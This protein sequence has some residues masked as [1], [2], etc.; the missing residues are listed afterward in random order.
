MSAKVLLVDDDPYNLVTLESILRPEGYTLFLAEDGEQ[1][2]QKAREIEPDVVVL[3]VMMPR[4]N[5]F[6]ACR[7]IRSDPVIGR[8]PILLL[9]ALDDPDSRLE[10]LRGGADDF[11]TKPCNRDEL[12]ARVRTV[13]ALNRF[14]VIAE[15]RERFKRLF[16][17]APDPILLVD[18][19]GGIVS[20]NRRATEVFGL[21]LGGADPRRE[22]ADLFV[23]DDAATVRDLVAESGVRVDP[24]PYTLRT[25][26]RA[27]G[28]GGGGAGERTF[29][30][31]ATVVPDQGERLH[32]VVLSDV[33]DV[34]AARSALETLNRDLDRQVQER[35]RQLEEANSL[36]LS[37]ANF[38][39]H[40]LRS[41]L[42]VVVG[43]LS[44]LTDDQRLPPD[45]SRWIGRA[46]HGAIN[47][48][49]LITN[50]L[51]LAHDEHAG[52]SAD[53]IVEAGPMMA[54]LVDRLSG[55]QREPVPRFVLGPLPTLQ[56]SGFVLERVFYNLVGNAIK[57]SS[58][59]PDPVIEI[60]ALPSSTPATAVLFVRDNGV[61]FGPEESDRLFRAFSR[62]SSAESREGL[63][64]GLSLVAR[65]VQAHRGRI[66]AEGRPNDG[67]TFFVELP[68]AGAVG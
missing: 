68:L 62:L 56:V 20:L 32:M 3:D 18:G 38:V 1:A 50:I 63:G 59:R 23:P 60:G 2:V 45:V 27:D 8:V 37:Y 35:T 46:Y 65:L 6:E 51:Q 16:T 11:I 22:I 52:I 5:G 43:C 55:L 58:H 49:E 26:A 53:Q 19:L 66:W 67:A 15:Q 7:R 4:M 24:V 61:G 30:A 41:P 39:S 34:V 25:A 10:G 9:T 40:D 13:V 17:L 14:R 28:E 36:L 12:R 54:R 31:R 64:L 21:P 33:T 44:V 47:L 57:Y 48:S 29:V 42:A